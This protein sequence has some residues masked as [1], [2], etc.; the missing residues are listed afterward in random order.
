VIQGTADDAALD[1]A[2]RLA[3]AGFKLRSL[4]STTSTQDVVR[5]AA[6][7]GAAPGFC[8]M[9]AAQTAGRGRQSRSWIAPPG[10]ALLF[11]VLV[12]V[13][14]TRL[15]GVSIA[16]GLAVRAAVAASSGG[17]G[18]LK[19]PNDILAGDRKLA[20]ILCEVEPAAP[21]D[22]TAVVIGAGVNL[23]VRSFP[24][25]VAG[26]SLHE[27]VDSPPSPSRLLA[28]VLPE[29]ASRLEVLDDMGMAQLRTEWMEHAAGLGAVVTA[30][31]AAGSVTG[32]AEG[33]D[34]EG[35][36]LVR[37]EAGVVRVL[38]GDVHLAPQA[39]RG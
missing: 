8:C 37:G 7:G 27:L 17:M 36:L 10:T 32:V 29:L 35:A 38:A 30:T 1:R 14:H 39:S 5:A 9:A 3:F 24:T 31:S 23:T 19:W 25:D 18:R 11:S 2:G 13:G 16:A 12:R 6:R 28:A 34:D 20:G 21:G 33:I 15:G 4:A 26:V 22:G